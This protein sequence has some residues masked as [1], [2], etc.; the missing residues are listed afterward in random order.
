[1]ETDNTLSHSFFQQA[2]TGPTKSKPTKSSS[3]NTT[4]NTVS[5]EDTETSTITCY[6]CNRPGH[7]SPECTHNTKLDGTPITSKSSKTNAATQIAE[8]ASSGTQLL[9]T[10]DMLDN[11]SDQLTADDYGFSFAINT[12][13]P[14]EII[15][16]DLSKATNSA[17]NAI[18]GRLNPF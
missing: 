11:W 16:E 3:P 9:V 4:T 15:I 7:I 1:M 14:K 5:D 8:A 13:Q 12:Q 10:D 2:T 17:L 6:T 18:D